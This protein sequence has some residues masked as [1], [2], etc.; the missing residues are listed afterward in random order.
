[1]SRT[2]L[3]ILSLVK[4]ITRIEG[5]LRPSFWWV[6]KK[7]GY[8]DTDGEA[9]TEFV[10]D[11][12]GHFSEGKA[13]VGTLEGE[14]SHKVGFIDL[15]GKYTP[16]ML[17]DWEGS[18]GGQYVSDWLTESY[19]ACFYNGYI[20]F[21][22]SGGVAYIFDKN[23]KQ[24][25]NN[26]SHELYGDAFLSGLYSEGLFQM[27]LDANYPEDCEYYDINK[28]RVLVFPG[29]YDTAGVDGFRITDSYEFHNG[30]AVG[31][32][33]PAGQEYNEN[34]YHLVLLDRNGRVAFARNCNNYTYLYASDMYGSNPYVN[35][36]IVLDDPNTG[37]YGAVDI[38][39]NIHV[40]FNFEMLYPL[41]EGM[42]LMKKNGLWGF[43]DSAGNTII[44]PQFESATPFNNGVA[45]ALKDGKSMAI[46]RYGNVLEGS[47]K[48]PMD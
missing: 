19:E 32:A 28:N 18:T 38:N 46:D 9:L 29:S 45:F 48:I 47:D 14:Y 35:G 12:A 21:Y 11:Y 41:H 2:A 31:W 33:L 30:Y 13:I 20:T 27:G 25:N 4:G 26:I 16:F 3:F 43:A 5:L 42:M 39:N 6:N 10:Y 37:L 23:G 34:S 22:E 7:R 15:D 17:G 36:L 44:E 1:M 40:P 24:L 8:V